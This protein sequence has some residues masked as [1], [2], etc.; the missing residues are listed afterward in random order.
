[1]A[2]RS[3]RRAFLGTSALIGTSTLSLGNKAISSTQLSVQDATAPAMEAVA[4]AWKFSIHRF[5]DPY[6]GVILRPETQEPGMRYVGAEVGI[7][8]ESE[9][10]L[11]FSPGSIRLR[12]TDGV[13]YTAGTVL[14]SDPR[15]L[16]INLIPGERARGW[17][18]FSVPEATQLVDLTYV[19]PAPRLTVPLPTESDAGAEGTPIPPA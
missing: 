11:N 9:A 2:T 12:D 6:T 13:E 18:W 15:I 1:M 3:T 17:V 7:N 8:N 10:A 4:P 14:G 5:R 19:A 16:D